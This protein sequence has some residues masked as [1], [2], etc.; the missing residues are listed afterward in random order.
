M[1]TAKEKQTQR[2]QKQTIEYQWWEG[3]GGDKIRDMGF[4]D[5][6]YYTVYIADKQEGQ[7]VE[8]RNYSASLVLSFDGV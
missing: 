4:R 3:S 1:Y 5:I 6:N 2:F 8:H 7:T